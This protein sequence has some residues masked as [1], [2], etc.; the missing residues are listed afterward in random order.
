MRATRALAQLPPPTRRLPARLPS[1]RCGRRPRR[2]DPAYQAQITGDA[3]IAVSA[4]T[5]TP[6]SPSLAR[7]PATA[8]L[9]PTPDDTARGVADAAAGR[10]APAGRDG[11]AQ[12]PQAQQAQTQQPSAPSRPTYGGGGGLA[13]RAEALV[14]GAA[15]ALGLVPEQA[16]STSTTA[17]SGGDGRGGGMAAPHR[18]ATTTTVAAAAAPESSSSSPPL[19]VEAAW[20]KLEGALVDAE[21]HAAYLERQLRGYDDAPGVKFSGDAAW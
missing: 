3:R 12:Q 11:A 8:H 18:A 10:Y 21:R 2:P 1:P 15:S 13:G 5:R 16:T 7:A 19:L 20:A 4:Q 9:R 6:A 17:G 14:E